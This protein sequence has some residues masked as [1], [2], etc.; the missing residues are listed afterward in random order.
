LLRA[1]YADLFRGAICLQVYDRTEYAD[2]LSGITLDAFAMG[3]P[4]L[5]LSRTWMATMVERFEAGV[6]VEEATCEAIYRAIQTICRAYDRYS[7]NAVRAGDWLKK[8][9]QWA[10]LIGA[11]KADSGQV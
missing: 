11:L 10:S 8:H 7:A 4:V 6:A 5:T 3:A 9:N 2:K 1:D